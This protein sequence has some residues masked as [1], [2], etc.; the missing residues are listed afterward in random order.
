MH[1]FRVMAMDGQGVRPQG[2]RPTPAQLA[3]TRKVTIVSQKVYSARL[4]EMGSFRSKK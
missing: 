1:K 3:A 2:P 4:P